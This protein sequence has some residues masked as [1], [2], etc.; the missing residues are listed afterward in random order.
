MRTISILI[1][2]IVLLLSSASSVLASGGSGSSEVKEVDGYMV[3]LTLVEGDAQ[4]GHNK[5]SIEIKDAQGEVVDDATVTV[6]AELYS[7]TSN[8][9][10]GGMGGMNM[11]GTTGTEED[12]SAE[13]PIRTASAEM[14]AGHNIGEYEGEIELAEAGHWMVKVVFLIQSHERVAEFTV[15]VAGAP[16]GW[17]ILGAFLGINIGIITVAVIIGKK[18]FNT[19]AAKEAK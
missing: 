17:V 5:L 6:V 4:I 3:E 1:F 10:T 15:E 9:G 13:A 18:R 19:P 7:E 8:N 14:E 16:R 2:S 11:G 12:T